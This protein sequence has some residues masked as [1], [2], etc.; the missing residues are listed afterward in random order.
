[1]AQWEDH[2]KGILRQ[3]EHIETG[4]KRRPE[5]TFARKLEQIRHIAPRKAEHFITKLKNGFVVRGVRL[6]GHGLAGLGG[7]AEQGAEGLAKDA[8]MGYFIGKSI[9]QRGWTEVKAAAKRIKTDLYNDWGSKAP[10]ETK[11]KIAE[12]PQAA[13]VLQRHAERSAEV[14]ERVVTAADTLEA[15][16]AEIQ[17]QLEEK[18]AKARELNK[19][20]KKIEALRS[21]LE[22]IEEE[23]NA[24]IARQKKKK[25]A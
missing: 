22:K 19:R 20:L 2:E 13:Q 11:K 6:F 14:Q 15:R 7:M 23:N 9:A 18:L 1:M 12:Q 16:L 4:K 8:T 5:K 25:A 10:Q 21:K 17:K 3:G 24:L